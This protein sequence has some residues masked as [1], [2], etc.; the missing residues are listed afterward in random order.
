VAALAYPHF[1]LVGRLCQAGEHRPESFDLKD[2][3]MRLP[4]A[5]LL[6]IALL[7]LSGCASMRTSLA[8][9]QSFPVFFTNAAVMPD[10][11]GLGVIDAAASWAKRYPGEQIS[12]TGY[13]DPRA[14][15]SEI[16]RL[17]ARRADEVAALLEDRGIAP[18]R[19]KRS[20]GDA[21]LLNTTGS[22]TSGL[23]NRRVDIAVG[24]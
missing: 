8:P 10:G 6:G 21:T 11:P 19:I 5:S 3:I 18:E 4:L 2:L 17:S 14:P 20:T 12:V 24:M 9:G 13:A 23:S 7:G 1:L 16:A 22:S 15:Q